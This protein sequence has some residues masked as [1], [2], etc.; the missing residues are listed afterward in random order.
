MLRDQVAREPGPAARIP[1]Q[2]A[3]TVAD[4]WSSCG[5]VKRAAQDDKIAISD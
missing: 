1:G 4:S 3:V 2:G 5:A